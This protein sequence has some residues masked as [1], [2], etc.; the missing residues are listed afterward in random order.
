M[1]FG[2]GSEP[3]KGGTISIG[4]SHILR[5]SDPEFILITRSSRFTRSSRSAGKVLHAKTSK[6]DLGYSR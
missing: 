1:P 5:T 3:W 6:K 4:T 2:V